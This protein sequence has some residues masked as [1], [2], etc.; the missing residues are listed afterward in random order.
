[1]SRGSIRASLEQKD[2]GP[3][4]AYGCVAVL[5]VHIYAIG[6]SAHEFLSEIRCRAR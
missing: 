5:H 4:S 3:R 6:I 2:A 1:M